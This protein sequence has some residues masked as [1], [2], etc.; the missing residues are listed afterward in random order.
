MKMVQPSY[1]FLEKWVV[2]VDK[3]TLLIVFSY[4]LLITHL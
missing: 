1:F 3:D 4:D 2:S